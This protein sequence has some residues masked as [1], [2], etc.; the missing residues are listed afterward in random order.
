MRQDQRAPPEPIQTQPLGGSAFTGASDARGSGA[1][2]P[3][4]RG[5]GSLSVPK[6]EPQLA[7]PYSDIFGTPNLFGVMPNLLSNVM[8]ASGGAAAGL[9]MTPGGGAMPALPGRSANPA[10][11]VSS[12]G[13][14]G[15]TSGLSQGPV[16][17]E[18]VY[19]AHMPGLAYETAF[20]SHV[21]PTSVTT[22]PYASQAAPSAV[23]AAS[24]SGSAAIGS[25]DGVYAGA[26]VAYE[27]PAVAYASPA[28]YAMPSGV[29]AAPATYAVANGGVSVSNGVYAAAAPQAPVATTS[30]YSGSSRQAAAAYAMPQPVATGTGYSPCPQGRRL[31]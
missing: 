2:S 31:Y 12:A 22:V 26:P 25:Y 15:Q 1:R 28:S 13:Y 24:Y 19:S 23:A 27:M 8:G 7:G 17:P 14:L 4:G 6:A 9:P 16:I 20:A 10:A 18:G 29:V 3:M 30:T 5:G 11:G 21:T